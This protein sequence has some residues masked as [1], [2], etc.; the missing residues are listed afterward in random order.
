MQLKLNKHKRGANS[1]LLEILSDYYTTDNGNSETNTTINGFNQNYNLYK[2]QHSP[3]VPIGPS[4]M[5][6][7]L[8]G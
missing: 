8:A 5:E 2:I 1:V 7:T 6:Q 4:L 3:L